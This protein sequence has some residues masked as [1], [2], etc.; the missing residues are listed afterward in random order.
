[1]LTEREERIV[2][3]LERGAEPLSLVGD[4]R[5]IMLAIARSIERGEHLKRPEPTIP[6][7]EWRDRPSAE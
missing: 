7:T 1:M 6:F 5:H 2:R 4:K 3:W